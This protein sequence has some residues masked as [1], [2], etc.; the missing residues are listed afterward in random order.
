MRL[1]FF[2]S[3]LLVSMTACQKDDPGTISMEGF[4][5]VRRQNH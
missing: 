2:V 1:P 4:E 3:V 5:S